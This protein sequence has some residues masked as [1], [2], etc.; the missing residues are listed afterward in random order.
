[1]QPKDLPR[2]ARLVVCALGTALSE[3]QSLLAGQNARE[4][5][6]ALAVTGQRATSLLD[7]LA[8]LLPPAAPAA[9]TRAGPRATLR[10]P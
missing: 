10:G 6:P 8:A 4:A 5:W 7:R 9:L 3:R 2:E 1:M